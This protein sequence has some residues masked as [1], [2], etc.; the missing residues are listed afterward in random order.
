MRSP[1]TNKS[2]FA[3][4]AALL[5]IVTATALVPALGP[6]TAAGAAT[7]ASSTAAA[8]GWRDAALVYTDGPTTAADLGRYLRVG[9]DPGQAAVYD[10]VIVNDQSAPSGARYEY[11]PSYASDWQALL[12]TYATADGSR[13]ALVNLVAAART[14]RRLDTKVVLGLPWP[15]LTNGSFR[16][17]TGRV[18]SFGTAAGRSQAI[19]DFVTVARQRW[20][21]SGAAA[22]G[23]T[24]WGTY[25][26]REDLGNGDSQVVASATSAIRSQG[27][28]TLWVPYYNAPMAAQWAS[29][30]FDA[31]SWQPNYA[32]YSYKDGGD[33][34]SARLTATVR[35]ATAA[36]AGLTLEVRGAA[37]DASDLGLL[38]EYLVA[39]RTMSPAAIRVH[40]LGMTQPLPLATEGSAPQGW[41]EL[42]AA[43]IARRTSATAAYDSTT[44]VDSTGIAWVALPATG[45]VTVSARNTVTALAVVEQ[46][47]S[48]GVWV[49]RGWAVL[50]P[51][52]E[53]PGLAA[54]SLPLTAGTAGTA[55][56]RLTMAKGTALPT[57]LSVAVTGSAALPVVQ[58]LPGTRYQVSGSAVTGAGAYPDKGQLTRTSTPP[59][60]SW[61][62]GDAIGWSGEPDRAG[63]LADLG[64]SKSLQAATLLV[65]GGG[66]A[67]VGWPRHVTMLLA[68]CPLRTTSGAGP[69]PCAVT[70]LAVSGPT[71]VHGTGASLTGTWT[72]TGPAVGRYLVVRSTVSTWSMWQRLRATATSGSGLP[73]TYKPLL[74]PS[75]AVA[76]TNYP[77]DGLRLTDGNAADALNRFLVTGFPAS[78][79]GTVTLRYDA[80]RS[81]GQLDAWFVNKP[82]WGVLVPSGLTA[83]V[84]GVRHPM[85]CVAATTEA[86]RCHAT[87]TRTTATSVTV[88]WPVAGAATS[89]VMVSEV[90]AA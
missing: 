6:S 72:G 29:L 62:S 45:Q 23:L 79:A 24:L 83:S 71:A 87:V 76:A 37:V 52:V 58:S 31:M 16:T 21:A 84:N 38:R 64:G 69:L 22:A 18:V 2:P 40:F 88:N 35:A 26:M 68:G 27:L 60:G 3:R 66:S 50:A 43:I 25:W 9:G 13:G 44:A 33:T 59:V 4:I 39:D 57:R 41:R 17:P 82:T 10:T 54:A 12:D 28:R 74:P 8:V 73:L 63:V 90:S 30:G 67:G 48:A 14:T 89:W 70:P 36:G 85:S 86:M 80:A 61:A 65:A 78:N 19:A 1:V 51:N 46:R 32:F 15:D 5:A 81:V 75:P 56:L 42:A 49:A 20:V 7:A 11:G 34:T 77:D 55:R 47:N 53:E